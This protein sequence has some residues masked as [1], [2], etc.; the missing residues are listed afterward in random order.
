[1]NDLD[2]CR[3]ALEENLADV[4][5]RLTAAYAAIASDHVRRLRKELLD[6]RGTIEKA[7]HT[8]QPR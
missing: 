3:R 8:L 2:A 7:L 4:D 1:M 5:R 6:H